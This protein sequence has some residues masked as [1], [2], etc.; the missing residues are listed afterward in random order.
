MRKPFLCLPLLSLL[1]LTAAQTSSWGEPFIV[2]NSALPT[3]PSTANLLSSTAT[4]SRLDV[5]TSP[6]TVP[7]VPDGAVIPGI[8]SAISKA[9][10]DPSGSETMSSAGLQS[11]AAAEGMGGLRTMGFAGALAAAAG[12]LAV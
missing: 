4:Q 6:P 9:S 10:F 1:G 11:A 2:D 5:A 7:S 8:Q 12:V 3:R